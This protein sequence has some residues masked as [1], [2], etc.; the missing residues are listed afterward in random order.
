MAGIA[1]EGWQP[2]ADVACEKGLPPRSV[3][4]WVRAKKLEARKRNGVTLVD[5]EAV[6]ALAAGRASA[7]AAAGAGNASP[8]GTG[9]AVGRATSS[10]LTP[11]LEAQIFERL[12]LGESPIDIVQSLKVSSG[13]VVTANKQYQEL[14][15]A[16]APPAARLAE[17]L[18]ALEERLDVVEVRLSTATNDGKLKDQVA[19]LSERFEAV[20]DDL[21]N[22]RAW[23]PRA[24][25]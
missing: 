13:V 24:R 16:A 15:Q 25:R 8:V 3:Y 7:K 23:G 22:F 1:P 17:R 11:E 10:V 12:G 4:N 9:M 14:R 19:Q 18:T 2:V 21:V 5:P 6:Q 20:E